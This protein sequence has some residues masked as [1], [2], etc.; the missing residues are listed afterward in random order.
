ML[1]E[2]SILCAFR[3]LESDVEEPEL[4]PPLRPIQLS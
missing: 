1:S 3:L 2:F 4:D